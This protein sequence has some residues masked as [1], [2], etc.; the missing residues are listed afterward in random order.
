MDM[1]LASSPLA[2]Y[3]SIDL[4]YEKEPWLSYE[5][6]TILRDLKHDVSD[7]AIDKVLAVQSVCANTSPVFSNAIAFEK[8]ITA[9][10]NNICV[11]DTWQPPFVEEL[12]YGVKSIL[13]LT[14]HIHG[15]KVSTRFTGEIPEYTA[16]VAKFRGWDILPKIL[17]YAQERLNFL[18]GL[19]KESKLYAEHKMLIDAIYSIVNNIDEDTARKM[20]YDDNVEQLIS[21]TSNASLS[22][23]RHLGALLYD[24]TIAYK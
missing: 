13:E 19:N 15:D 11:M 14:K 21:G 16:S 6:E 24:P 3:K 17:S 22:L 8:A 12:C 10:C 2:I 9:F 5:P 7:I 1:L 18:T 23:R 4:V 20:L